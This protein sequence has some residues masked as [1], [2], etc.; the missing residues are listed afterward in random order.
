ARNTRT[1]TRT[2]S[3]PE[4]SGRVTGRSY[5][6]L[7]ATTGSTRL[8]RRPGG[9]TAGGAHGRKESHRGGGG[10]QARALP[11]DHLCHLRRLRTERHPDSN[12]TRS[13]LDRVRH[14]SIESHHGD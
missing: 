12:L 1:R 2:C 7:R 10:P 6:Y 13:L 11:E 9:P 5:S 4:I 14:E 8:G 3:D